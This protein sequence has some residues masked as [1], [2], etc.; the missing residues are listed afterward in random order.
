MEGGRERSEE[1]KEAVG[2]DAEMLRC[3]GSLV[4]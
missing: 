2:G 1:G 3:A 4:G